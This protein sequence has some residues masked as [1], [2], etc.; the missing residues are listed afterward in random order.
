[1]VDFTKLIMKAVGYGRCST[2]EQA[3]NGV[4]IEVQRRA[5][6]RVAVSNG[7]ALIWLGDQ[8]EVR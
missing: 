8:L 6:E 5:V 2:A 7:W 3:S 1:M 4:S